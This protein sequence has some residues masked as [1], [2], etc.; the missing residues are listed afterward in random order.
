MELDSCD[1]AEE[2]QIVHVRKGQGR[3]MGIGAPDNAMVG[4]SAFGLSSLRWKS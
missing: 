4:G 2:P 1:Q 3:M